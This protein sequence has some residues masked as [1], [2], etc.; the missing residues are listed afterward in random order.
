MTLPTRID[1]VRGLRRC[2][3]GTCQPQGAPGVLTCGVDGVAVVSAVTLA[4][5]PQQAALEGL[6]LAVFSRQSL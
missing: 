2:C 3:R 4:S 5:A 6:R 1:S